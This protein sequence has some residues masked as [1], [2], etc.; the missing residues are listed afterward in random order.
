MGGTSWRY[1]PLKGAN[2]SKMV[3]CETTMK[4]LVRGRLLQVIDDDHFHGGSLRIEAQTQLVPNGREHRS[5]VA[6]CGRHIQTG[7]AAFTDR[8]SSQVKD[9]S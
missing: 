2:V 5:V 4:A 7:D 9:R 6:R 8:A 3:L 1:E